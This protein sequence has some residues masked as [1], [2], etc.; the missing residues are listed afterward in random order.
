[1]LSAKKVSFEY[2]NTQVLNSTTFSVSAGEKIALVGPNG[3]GKSTLL[4]L[5]GGVINPTEGSV[6]Y[7][8]YLIV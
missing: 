6:S 4:K 7:P 5:L 2:D 1:M 8:N 3:V